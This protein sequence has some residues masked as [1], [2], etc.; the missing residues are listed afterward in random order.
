MK[1]KNI[2]YNKMNNDKDQNPNQTALLICNH[3]KKLGK[4]QVT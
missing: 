3:I 1:E 4:K 2:I